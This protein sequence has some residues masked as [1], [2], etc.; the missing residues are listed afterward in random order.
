[1]AR[2]TIYTNLKRAGLFPLMVEIEKPTITITEDGENEMSYASHIVVDGAWGPNTGN[3]DRESREELVTFESIIILCG[4]FPTIEEN[5]RV[6]INNSYYDIKRVF[7]DR[8]DMFTQLGV[9]RVK[10]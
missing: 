4:F 2:Q 3:E 6:K 1:M 5:E 9:D 7:S 10:Q 8:G